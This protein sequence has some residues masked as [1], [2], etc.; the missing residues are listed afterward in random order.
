MDKAIEEMLGVGGAR[1]AQQSEKTSFDTRLREWQ[2]AQ[3]REK[4]REK[5]E[6]VRLARRAEVSRL[7]PKP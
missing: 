6:A 3:D 2:E 5:N 7:N 1:K 4:M